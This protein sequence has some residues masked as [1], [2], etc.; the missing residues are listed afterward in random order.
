MVAIELGG[1]QLEGVLVDSGST[2]SV[3]DRRHGR[4]S[5]EETGNCTLMTWRKN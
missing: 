2:C 4:Y 1:V 3:V 5:K